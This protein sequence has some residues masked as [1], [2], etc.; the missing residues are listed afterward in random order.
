LAE[1]SEIERLAERRR[2]LIAESD[3]CRQEIAR[4][5]KSLGAVTAWAE[6]GYSVARSVR[7]WWPVLGVAAGFLITRRKGS[8]FRALAKGWSWWQIGKRFAPMWRRAYEAFC[9]KETD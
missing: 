8:L 4:E 2:Q 7:A 6:K 9:S 3:R 5:L 1:F